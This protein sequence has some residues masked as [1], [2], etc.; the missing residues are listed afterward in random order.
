[1]SE[2]AKG[3][4]TAV[5]EE[6]ASLLPNLRQ[7]GQASVMRALGHIYFWETGIKFEVGQGVKRR[8]K[9]FLGT[10]R[11]DSTPKRLHNKQKDKKTKKKKERNKKGISGM[12]MKRKQQSK[13]Q[14]DR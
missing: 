8:T 7:L 12:E 9:L 2:Q 10:A 5:R 3:L 13:G 14:Q 6:N 11:I 1:M 4:A